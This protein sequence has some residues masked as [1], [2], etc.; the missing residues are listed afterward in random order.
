MFEDQGVIEA[1]TTGPAITS[2]N[3]KSGPTSG[4]T[5]VT[6]SGSGF[7]KA[8]TVLFGTTGATPKVSNDGKTI[9]VTS[10]SAS[11]GGVVDI[12]VNVPTGKSPVVAA[13][14]F[15]YVAPHITGVSPGNGPQ[16]GGT[17]VTISGQELSATTKVQFGGVP[18][19]PKSVSETQ[20]VVESPMG[21]VA[22][23]VDI[24]AELPSG[25]TPVVAA[26]KFAYIAPSVT[27]LDPDSAPITG[28]TV[29]HIYGHGLTGATAVLFGSVGATPIQ[30]TDSCITVKA[31][32]EAK[33][34]KVNVAVSLPSGEVKAASEFK[35][36]TPAPVNALFVIDNQTGVPDEHVYVKFLGAEINKQTLAQT[37]GDDQALKTGGQT[38]SCSYSLKEMTASV[39]GAAGLP[40]PVPQFRINDYAGGRIYFS[41][42]AELAAENIPAAQNPD[43][44]DF[45]TVYG[46][47]EPSIFPSVA[48]GNTN[49]D[50]SYVDFIA[51]PVDVSIRKRAD[52]SLAKP[53]ANNPLTTPSGDTVFLALTGDSN[54]P[55][56]T[57]VSANTSVPQGS[58]QPTLSIGGTARILSPSTY[59]SSLISGATAYHDWTSTG[60]LIDTLQQDATSLLVASYTTGDASHGVP[61]QTLFGFSGSKKSAIGADW[62][63]KQGYSLT[64]TC[65]KDLNKDGANPRI[66]PLQGKAGVCISGKGDT[67]GNFDIYITNSDL[68]DPSGIYGA[69]PPY[70]VDWLDAPGQATAYVMA[71]IQNDL[72][73]RVVGDLLAGFNFGWAGCATTVK[74]QATATDTTANLSGTVFDTTS[75]SLAGKAIGELSTGEFFYLLSLQPTTADIAKWFGSAIQQGN[76]EWYNNYASDFQ[77]LTNCYNMAFTDR[78]QGQSDPDMFFSPSEETYVQVTLLPGAYTVTS[79]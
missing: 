39:A 74:D 21:Q 25:L 51:I 49:I 33:A 16:R 5:T 78:L 10:P 32:A 76:P 45:N 13:D 43:D 50:A 7:S 69:N 57:V 23:T 11:E 20:L 9:T 55:K 54:I 67:V 73:G 53:P 42:G 61:A 79:S 14:Q 3:P 68:D 65:L 56:D 4:G 46:F 44:K 71:G 8:M 48:E 64:A 15:T 75:G 30:V 72:G 40:K 1:A 35:Y 22:G 58:A 38:A 37:Y 77:A 17:E 24:R 6:I 34:G 60:G 62:S 31:P 36:Y 29:V 19:T 12:R 63:K 41:L 47:V 66:A 70:T 2:I 18:V 59:E 28:G 27:G 26:D 52:G